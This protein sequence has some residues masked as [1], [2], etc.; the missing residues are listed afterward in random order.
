MRWRRFGSPFLILSHKTVVKKE[1]LTN[2]AFL[3]CYRQLLQ[4]DGVMHLKTDNDGFFAYTLDQVRELGLTKIAETHDLYHSDL[5]DEVLS[6]K[7]YYEKKYLAEGKNIN[8]L[9]WKFDAQ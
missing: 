6:I 1:R 9:Q 7:T 3:A 8:Y 2:V 4:P 5:L